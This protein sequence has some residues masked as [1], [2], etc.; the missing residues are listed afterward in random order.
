MAN[1]WEDPY[2][3]GKPVAVPGFPR[4]LYPPDAANHDKTPSSDGPD[5]EAYK[6][7]AWRAGRWQGPAVNFDRAFSNN[8]SHG[9][10][11]GTVGVSGIAGLQRQMSIDPTGW[12]GKATFDMMRRIRVPEG[13][14][15][16]EPCM[17]ANAANLIAQAYAMYQGVEP[18]A[19]DP[20]PPTRSTRQRALAA[21]IGYL[22]DKE[23][24]PDSN[25]TKYGKWYGQDGQPWCAMFV[26]YVYEV[27]AGGSPS[28][29]K[30]R[31]YAYCPYVL[32]DARNNRNGLSV[33]NA[34]VAGDLVLYDWDGPA[35]TSGG[36][37]DHIG[38][39]EEWVAYNA[40]TFLAI[41]GNTSTSS[42]SNGGEVQRRTRDTRHQATVFVRVAGP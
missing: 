27:D 15:F 42:N 41:E 18:P 21:A 22:G 32:S 24:P 1:W 25:R 3:T 6:R 40:T 12:V 26:S 29:E 13:P 36:T 28:F 33:T 9:K 23:S 8:F 34:P 14:H 5:V 30:G 19:P 10:K 7:V 37:F 4:P 20:S 2:K 11:S 39:F 35:G 31:N 38:L 17:D 16:G